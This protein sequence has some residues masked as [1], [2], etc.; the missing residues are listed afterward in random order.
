MDV[1]II[2]NAVLVPTGQTQI[3]HHEGFQHL[4]PIDTT[5]SFVVMTPRGGTKEVAKV[6]QHAEFLRGAFVHQLSSDLTHLSLGHQITGADGRNRIV[7]N[8]QYTK[9][10]DSALVFASTYEDGVEADPVSLELDLNCQDITPENPKPQDPG[11]NA[12]APVERSAANDD[13]SPTT[14]GQDDSTA[15]STNDGSNTPDN[16][17]NDTDNAGSKPG[18]TEPTTGEGGAATPADN[19][20]NPNNGTNTSG[21]D[22]APS[23]ERSY[24]FEKSAQPS[25]SFQ[26]SISCNSQ[27]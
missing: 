25:L 23:A 22:A 8:A 15:G 6:G 5:R 26:F 4:F 16:G 1:R 2:A 10:S 14:G 11:V 19:T 7:S 13:S 24:V 21:N 17:T 18:G 3:L 27:Y 20:E 9:N 12:P